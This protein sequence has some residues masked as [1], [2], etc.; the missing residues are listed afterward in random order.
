M[1]G[2]HGSGNS[3]SGRRLRSLRWYVRAPIKL[4]V[5]AAVTFF[6]LFPFPRQ[7]ARHL[8]RLRNLDAMVEPDAPQLAEWEAELRSWMLD[9][10]AP[11]ETGFP[12][13]KKE[14]GE[15]D[16]PPMAAVQ[17]RIQEM[18]FQKVRYAWDWDTWGSADYIPTVSEMF[19]TAADDPRGELHEDCD[20][21]AVIAA[22]LI[23]RMGY[24]ADLVT[25]LRHVWVKTPQGEWMGPGKSKALVSTPEGTRLNWKVA[26]GNVPMSISYGISVFPLFRE[27]LILATAFVL[28]R[29]SRTPWRAILLSAVLLVQG[30]LFMRCGVFSPQQIAGFER[31]WPATVGLLHIA[32]G[33]FLLFGTSYKARC[34]ERRKRE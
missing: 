25:D 6:V 29:H 17:K 4:F 14:L 11:G 3:A 13:E 34:A 18:V 1:F 32:S 12:D 19:A 26:L 15:A 8:S 27:L 30:L 7:F 20:G 23:R 16:I 33:I 9:Y 5:F 2:R 21:R 22:S 10:T 24:E 31:S 28:M